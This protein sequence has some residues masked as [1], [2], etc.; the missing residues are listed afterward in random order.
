MK[1]KRGI[2]FVLCTLLC[3][4]ADAVEQNRASLFQHH[5]ETPAET[6]VVSYNWFDCIHC[7]A[8]LSA[9]VE[10]RGDDAV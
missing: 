6:A 10:Q 9:A 7:L 8:S 4:T 5:D 3:L 1:P 2:H